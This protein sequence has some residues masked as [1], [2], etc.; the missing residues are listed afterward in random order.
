[1]TSQAILNDC[2]GAPR[3]TCVAGMIPHKDPRISPP[4]P[5]NVGHRPRCA[6]MS[7]PTA[8]AP[9]KSS[10]ISNAVMTRTRPAAR[11]AAWRL[12]PFGIQR[13]SPRMAPGEPLPQS[14]PNREVWKTAAKG[15]ADECAPWG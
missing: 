4:A 8:L 3:A 13:E 12:P 9:N 11:A 15:A 10:A 1:G 2:G 6:K 14:D 7:E 5:R